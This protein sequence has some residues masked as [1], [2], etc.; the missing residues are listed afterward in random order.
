AV[1][2]FDDPAEGGLAWHHANPYP[3]TGPQSI[4]FSNLPL[5]A[6]SQIP[7]V[8]SGQDVTLPVELS[9]FTALALGSDLV[10][11]SWVTQS[12]SNLLGFKVLKNGCNLLSTAS[13]ISDLIPATNSSQTTVYY[14]RD[15]DLVPQ[16]CYYYWLETLDLNGTNR[17]LGPQSV[18]V[19]DP[20]NP[21]T[22]YIPLETRLLPSY[23]NPFNPSTTIHYQLRS[24]ER[25][26]FIIYSAKGQVVAT[27]SQI[28]ANPGD[29]TWIFRGVDQEGN[30]LASGL[31]FCVMTAG[32][33]NYTN[34][35]VLLK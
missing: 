17:F 32:N 11:L 33:N 21:G 19:G 13:V 9:S 28:H 20:D 27:H 8:L 30:P 26:D 14:F 4:V 15:E 29:Y 34:K 6:K 3:A 16:T 18:T 24:P 10:T 22:P 1:A 5:G 35:M 2:Y 23:P 31:Y 12:E 25:V 7:A